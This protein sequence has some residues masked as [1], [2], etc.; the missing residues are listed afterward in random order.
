[1]LTDQEI[2][3][4][5]E[6][7]KMI[8]EEKQQL[9]E[10]APL[11]AFLFGIFAKAGYDREK[12]RRAAE[13]AA[14]AAEQQAPGASNAVNQQ[15]QPQRPTGILKNG[16]IIRTGDMVRELQ[17]YLGFQGADIDGKFGPKTERAVRT[18]QQ[19]SGIEVDGIVGPNTIQKI[20]QY[21]QSGNTPAPNPRPAPRNG[22]IAPGTTTG[23][24]SQLRQRQAGLLDS[25]EE[26]NM[27]ESINEEITITGDPES[28]LRMMKLAGA[29]DAKEVDAGDINPNV[30]SSCGNRNGDLA[31][32]IELM[33]DENWDNSPDEDVA[34]FDANPP[35]N[36]LNKSKTSH[37]P[38]AGGDNPMALED[39]LRAKLSAALEEKKK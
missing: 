3:I 11:L 6:E 30:G 38:A 29:T 17:T 16:R 23:G 36:D 13:A 32:S 20:R 7:Q 37:P 34:D 28:L 8:N 21:S 12:A 22:G 35:S 33:A 18:F 24:P 31:R 9:N 25:I 4:I 19:N 14:G 10:V 1:M 2:E 15:G 39:E 5:N 26:T 27:S